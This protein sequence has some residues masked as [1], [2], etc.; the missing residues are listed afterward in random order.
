MPKRYLISGG[1]TGGHIFPAI[2][3]GQALQELS[4]GAELH[5]IGALGRM[6][7]EKIP[8][9]GYTITGLPIRGINR[10]KPWKNL[11]LPLALWKSYRMAL[12][13]LKTFRPDAAIGVGGYASAAMGLAASK[14]GIPLILQEQ[15][16]FPGKTNRWL[17]RRAKAICVAHPGMEKYFEASKLHLTGN[18]V[19]KAFETMG[20]S[21]QEAK[22]QLGLDS[23]KPLVFLT[24]GS[25]GAQALNHALYSC[26]PS[27]QAMGVQVLWQTGS[28]SFTDWSQKVTPAPGLQ[29]AD[30]IPDMALA[31]RAADLVISRAG[32]IALAEM[33]MTQTPSL[34]VPLP[35]AAE[36]HQSFNAKS[37]EDRGG[38]FML[39]QNQLNDRLLPTLKE[40]LQDQEKLDSMRKALGSIKQPNAAQNIAK[41]IQAHQL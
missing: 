2:A 6:E 12:A 13:T 7:M 41:I 33:A 10:S 5:F 39:P 38:A 31:F 24:G 1:G 11:S 8:Q 4:P 34:L 15:N 9:A 37:I 29:L 35:G 28:R 16:A 3:I 30:F 21:K 27:L 23:S 17:S 22:A 20:A 19:R 25:L 26:L 40:L 18:P 32:A 36:D 14:A